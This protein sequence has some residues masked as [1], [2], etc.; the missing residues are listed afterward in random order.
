[1]VILFS[2]SLIFILWSVF[3]TKL[4]TLD[5]SFSITVRVVVVAKLLIYRHL[6]Y[7]LIYFF[8]SLKLVGTFFNLSMSNLSTLY[9]I[10]GKSTILSKF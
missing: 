10:L 7:L 1:M 5:V 6:I 2:T 9:F 3:F 8:K 4:L